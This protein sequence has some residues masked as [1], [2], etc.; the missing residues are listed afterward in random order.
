MDRHS[1][2]GEIFA[3]WLFKLPFFVKQR[4]IESTFVVLD[5]LGGD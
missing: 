4:E 1:G 3:F 2:L 5:F